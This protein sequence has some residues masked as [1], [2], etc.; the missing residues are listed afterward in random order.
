MQRSKKKKKSFRARG[1]ACCCVSLIQYQMVAVIAP[2][3][4][5]FFR[6]TTPETHRPDSVQRSISAPRGEAVRVLRTMI[7]PDGRCT[8]L[9]PTTRH[10]SDRGVLAAI[11]YVRLVDPGAMDHDVSLAV[12]N[13]SGEKYTSLVTYCTSQ[14]RG[15]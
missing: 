4:V 14:P 12:K 3:S 1:A 5:V 2:R 10:L 6:R 7:H 11:V 8:K 15:N 9:Y 13:I